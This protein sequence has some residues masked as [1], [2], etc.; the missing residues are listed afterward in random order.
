MPRSAP[1]E[2][3]ARP[4]TVTWPVLGFSKPAIMFWSV[5]FTTPEGPSRQRNSSFSTE[6]VLSSSAR[7]W[8]LRFRSRKVLLAFEI[9]IVAIS[10]LPALNR[11]IALP[12][13]DARHQSP[14]CQVAEIA[15]QSDAGHGGEHEVVAQEIIG[16]PEHIAE[17]ALHRDQLGRHG[18]HPRRA[19]TDAQ[20]CKYAGQRRGQDDVAQQLP[21]I[22]A[23]HGAGPD[24]VTVATLH[25]MNGVQQDREKR[26]EKH[27]E[28]R[29]LVGN[30]EPDDG[31]V[32]PRHLWD[33]TQNLQGRLDDG[34]DP[35]RPADGHPQRH[36][37]HGCYAEPNHHAG[38]A[39]TGLENP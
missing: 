5:D 30:A 15:E 31:E 4:S 26:A 25:T 36:A 33:R 39:G 38:D 35:P 24:Q 17:A 8:V 2:V 20:A 18:Q 27:Q 9:S 11:G 16:I 3:V 28:D 6:R 37:Q 22:A 23:N 14:N 1:G 10:A 19:D 7:T 29:R 34:L 13:Q 12:V 32:N 21:L